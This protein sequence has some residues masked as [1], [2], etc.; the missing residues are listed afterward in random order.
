VLERVKF[1]ERGLYTLV[2]PCVLEGNPLRLQLLVIEEDVIVS[3][4]VEWRVDVHKVHRLVGNKLPQDVEAVT[5]VES[6][7]VVGRIAVLRVFLFV[8]FNDN[9][10][11]FLT[12]NL[13]KIWKILW[14]DNPEWLCF[15]FR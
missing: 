5:T 4:R 7:H 12:I 8:C 2:R 6:V 10:G 9:L 13:F 14:E 3:L 1:L 15:E 11:K